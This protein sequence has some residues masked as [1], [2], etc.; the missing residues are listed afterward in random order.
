MMDAVNLALALLRRRP[1]SRRGLCHETQRG[2]LMIQAAAMLR[3]QHNEIKKLKLALAN[4]N[5][6]NPMIS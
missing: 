5:A 1:Y 3:E 4:K 6:C 2:A